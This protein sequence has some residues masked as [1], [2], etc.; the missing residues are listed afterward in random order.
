MLWV[1][2]YI[3]YKREKREIFN[4]YK[5]RLSQN[6]FLIR[7]HFSHLLTYIVIFESSWYHFSRALAR[8]CFKSVCLSLIMELCSGLPR[9]LRLYLHL[10]YLVSSLCLGLFSSDE[11]F[12]WLWALEIDGIESNA[13]FKK[14]ASTSFSG[15]YI[16]DLK[17]CWRSSSI[18]EFLT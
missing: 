8:K 18:L 12:P 10:T 15:Y 11:L 2:V 7:V 4:I 5:K 3:M 1:Y 13:F 6:F 14:F 16:V 9:L 17:L